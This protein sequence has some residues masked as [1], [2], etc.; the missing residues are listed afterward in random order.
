MR[1]FR[2]IA[3]P[4]LVYALLGATT[5]VA[6]A[7]GFAIRGLPPL[8]ASWWP[9]ARQRS[10]L[11]PVDETHGYVYWPV[12]RQTGIRTLYAYHE[13]A[14]SGPLPPR[15][16]HAP[17]EWQRPP[18]VAGGPHTRGERHFGFPFVAMWSATETLT[19]NQAGDSGRE[20]LAPQLV[21]QHVLFLTPYNRNTQGPYARLG[22][23]PGPYTL[24]VPTGLIP[25]GF[26]IN[27]VLY[28]AAW[29]VL[30]VGLARCRAWNR[31]RRGLCVKCT[32]DLRGLEPSMPCP[33]CGRQP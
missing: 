13:S 15:A 33:E 16:E 21:H 10:T 20:V 24:A 30:L 12:M 3:I 11:V 1:R 25:S 6:V 32:Y 5:T 2:A 19:P 18:V 29:W 7:W 26:A 22:R 17:Q 28:A 9:T 31:Q 14:E 8:P 27:T 23:F 4:L